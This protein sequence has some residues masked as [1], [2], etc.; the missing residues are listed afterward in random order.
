M[1]NKPPL[2]VLIVGASGVFG[3]RLARLA[4]S[5]PGIEL[6]LGGRRRPPLDAL[7]AELGTG[8]VQVIDRDRASASELTELDLV[9]DCA[10]PFQGSRT[11]LIEH[12]IAAGVDYVDLADGR[13]FVRRI[14]RFD[15]AAK[16]AGVRVISGASSIP[17]LSHAVLD[18]LTA[19]WS[20]IDSIRVGI[21]PGNRAPRGRSVVEAIL[22]Y[23][24]KPVRV[25]ADGRWTELPGWALCG[26]VDCGPAGKRW[27]SVCDT[28][29]QDLLVERY[30]PTGSAEFV[31]GLEL[32]ILHLGLWLLSFPVRW[33][34]IR[35]L[36]P[37]AGV[38]L[39]IASRLRRFGSDRGAML[40]EARGQDAAGRALTSAWMLDATTNRGPFVP[41]L[42]AL[43]LIKRARDGRLPPPGAG[44]CSGIL[45]LDEFQA[46]FQAL[47]IRTT[48]APP[49]DLPSA[50]RRRAA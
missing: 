33:G 35:S 40:V 43:A 29:E 39:W 15:D 13:K 30:R 19:G 6:V 7:V 47:G 37:A 18:E 34:W 22:S 42:A 1:S 46:M 3:S 16:R 21:F 8:L 23:T 49:S 28:P 41:V 5:E 44:P 38:L 14:R 12:C 31:A 4:A 2:R 36:A 11:Q 20:R 10:G 17:A 32:P 48:I 26:R 9:I 27:A 50:S 45:R 24:G 25:F